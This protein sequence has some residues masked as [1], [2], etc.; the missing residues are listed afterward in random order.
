MFLTPGIEYVRWT[1]V[2]VRTLNKDGA[3]VYEPLFGLSGNDLIR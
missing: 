1:K 2:S 3:V